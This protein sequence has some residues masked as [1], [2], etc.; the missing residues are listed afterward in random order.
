MVFKKMLGAFGIGAPSV[1]TVLSNPNTRPGLLLAGQVNLTGG[2]HDVE[3]DHVVVGLVT[4]VEVDGTQ[5]D[6]DVAFEFHRAPVASGLRLA[7]GQQLALPFQLPMPFQTPVTTIYGQELP[8]ITVGLRTEVAVRGAVDKGDLDAVQ[9]HPLPVQERV[10]EA[11]GQLGFRFKGADLERGQIAGAHQSLPFHQGIAYFAAPQYAHGVHEVELTF[12]TDEQ[13]VDVLLRLDRRAG[14]N[15]FGHGSAG[16]YRAAHADTNRLDWA[17]EVDRWLREALER[18]A[19]QHPAPGY[20]QPIPGQPAYG[21][22]QE[23]HER[24]GPGMGAVAAGVVGGEA[25]GLAGGMIADEV[26]DS[27]GGDEDDDG[28]ADDE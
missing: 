10:L 9:V 18:H 24:R 6:R 21:G 17:V 8:G 22:H 19:A 16:C 27:F 3:I 1:D 4:R 2:S 15:P 11:F 14:L 5:G 20:G 7:Q 26:F 12:L 25:L 13:G 28:G 23:Q